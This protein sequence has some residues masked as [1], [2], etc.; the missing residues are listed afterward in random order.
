[1]QVNGMIMDDTTKMKVRWKSG[2]QVK[3][4]EKW[5]QCVKQTKEV[6]NDGIDEFYA[7]N[8]IEMKIDQEAE[9]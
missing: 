7:W 6:M 5:R 1:M 4:P 3:E 9:E 8:E 2:S